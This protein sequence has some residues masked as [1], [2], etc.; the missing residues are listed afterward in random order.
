M[1]FPVDLT[2]TVPVILS[3]LSLAYAWW[4]TRSSAVDAR[5][6]SG[7]DRMDQHELRVQSLEQTV[8]SLPDRNDLH[9][10]QLS[11]ERMNGTMGRME[12]VLEGN[13]QIMGRLEAIVSRHEDHLL[14]GSK[15]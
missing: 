2:V 9:R 5:F 15:R 12:A 11:M 10:I 6:K 1:T 8:K 4:R 3:F 14:Q 7:S 13:Q